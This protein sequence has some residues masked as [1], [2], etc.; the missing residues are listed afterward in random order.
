M[1]SRTLSAL[2]AT[3]LLSFAGCDESSTPTAPSEQPGANTER[4]AELPV[5]VATR[6]VV[7]GTNEL[8][9]HV[10]VDRLFLNVGAVLL[11]PVDG[12]AAS[13]SSRDPLGLE[14]DLTGGDTD[15]FGP[16]LVLPYGGTYAVTVQIEPTEVDVVRSKQAQPGS[17][18][19][20]GGVYFTDGDTPL[21]DGDEPSPLPWIP[22]DNDKPGDALQQRSEA[23]DTV[24][25][26]YT[27]TD[28][29]RFRLDEIRLDDAGRHE[30]TFVIHLDE[31]LEGDL[32]PAL[33]QDEDRRHPLQQLDVDA[34]QNNDEL[35]RELDGDRVGLDALIGGIQAFSARQ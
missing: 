5:E 8:D 15:L 31:W 4:T 6:F 19:E 29:V 12:A 25:F 18:V 2:A 33:E 34:A 30:L 32:I 17:S 3:A 13:F 27:A 16:D 22:K 14:F 28:I 35:E 24:A 10:V 1:N 23:A 26:S 7:Q 20:V 11:D 21:V 9:E